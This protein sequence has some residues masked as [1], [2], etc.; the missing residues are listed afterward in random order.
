MKNMIEDFKDVDDLIY[1]TSLYEM[2]DQVLKLIEQYGD[3]G[4]DIDA[5][6]NNVSARILIQR[7]ETEQ[8]YQKRLKKEAREKEEAKQKKE[9]QEARERKEY[10][11]LKEKFG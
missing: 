10:E 5:G 9:K 11:R 7:E 1:S 6:Y 2:R 3:A 8:E 4:L